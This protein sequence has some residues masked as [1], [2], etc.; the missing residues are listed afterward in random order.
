MSKF[1]GVEP[2]GSLNVIKFRHL[3][4][5]VNTLLL[6][7]GQPVNRLTENSKNGVADL[8]LR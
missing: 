4:T 7:L 1:L 8:G 2:L 6:I 5:G 3:F